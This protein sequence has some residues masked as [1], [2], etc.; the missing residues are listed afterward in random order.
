[1]FVMHFGRRLR[2]SL[3]IN[4]VKYECHV[5]VSLYLTLSVILDR[6][7]NRILNPMNVVSDNWFQFLAIT[8]AKK[9]RNKLVNGSGT[10]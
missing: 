6:V 7:K 3:L 2:Q 5:S 8:I 9:E 1:M 10:V 4:T